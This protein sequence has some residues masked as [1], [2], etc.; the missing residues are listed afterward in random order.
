MRYTIAGHE[1]DLTEQISQ[2]AE[3]VLWAKD[4]IGEAVKA[5]PEASIA[6]AGVSLILP[7]LTNPVTAEEANRDGFAYVTTRMRYYAALEPLLLRLGKSCGVTDALMAEN[8]VRTFVMLICA[9]D[10]G[11]S[12]LYVDLIFGEGGTVSCAFDDVS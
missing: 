11:M 3:L 2:A 6:W 1:C 4:W 5:S 12:D 8:H 10:A 7:L 9:A